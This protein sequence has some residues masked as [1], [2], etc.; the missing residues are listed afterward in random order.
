MVTVVKRVTKHEHIDLHGA[1]VT[2]NGYVRSVTC[3]QYQ[4]DLPARGVQVLV[5]Y[6]ALVR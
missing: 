1:Y 4:P 3:K 5:G 6:G 2:G